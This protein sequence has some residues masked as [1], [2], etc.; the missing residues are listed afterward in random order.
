[1]L[2]H[3]CLNHPDREAAARCPGCRRFFCRECVTEHAGR[4]LCAR[5]LPAQLSAPRSA[6]DPPYWLSAITATLIGLGIAWATFLA[7][8]TF[9]LRI[10]SQWHEGTYWDQFLR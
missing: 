6:G 9:L 8:G 7:L 4:I 3:L 2:R 1:M 5:C 10:P